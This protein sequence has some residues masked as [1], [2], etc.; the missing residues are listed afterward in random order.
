MN[1]PA[2]FYRQSSFELP[3]GSIRRASYG[4]NLTKLCGKNWGQTQVMQDKLNHHFLPRFYL[5]GFADESDTSHIWEYQRGRA[6]VPGRN[7]RDKYN[8]VFISPLKRS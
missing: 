2:H 5:K 1:L 4:Y 3:C 7:N 8:P 6:Y